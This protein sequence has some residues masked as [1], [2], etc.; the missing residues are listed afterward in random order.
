MQAS[1]ANSI[2]LAKGNLLCSRYLRFD[3][4]ARHGYQYHQLLDLAH[5]EHEYPECYTPSLT[6]LA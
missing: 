2:F 5:R 1:F 6:R 4:V 3:I